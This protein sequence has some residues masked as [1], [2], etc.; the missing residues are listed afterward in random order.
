MSA[1]SLSLPADPA[2]AI[3]ALRG[4][5]DADSVPPLV[6]ETS[7]STGR[8]KRVLLSREAV[9]ASARATSAVIGEGRWA[10]ALPPD[11]IAGA[12]VIV[13]SLLAGHDPAL[14]GVAAAYDEGARFV[15]L[16][17]TQL[18]RMLADPDEFSVLASYRAVLVGGGPSEPGLLERARA[19][20]VRAITTYGASETA[21]GCV[22]DGRPLPGVEVEVDAEE[23]I[24]LGGPTIFSGYLDDPEATAQALVGGRFRTNDAGTI[25]EDGRLRVLGRLD[26]MVITGGIKVPAPAVAA[27][28]RAHPAV[29]EAEVLGVP[30]A[31]WGRRVVAFVSVN[32]PLSLADARDWIAAEHPRTWAPRQ[33]VAVD[34]WP[35]LGN[36]KLD[37]RALEAMA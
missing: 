31:E 33:L 17:P 35:V 25:G 8:P 6:V 7:G 11:Y 14:A 30:D 12:Q 23:R 26:D 27:R 20:G 4:W 22:Y 18:H 32:G 13:R 21:G 2:A 37:R 19:A 3:A 36:G 34:E 5:L 9:L 1:S 28:L 10:L 24:W 29:A 16:V 15:S